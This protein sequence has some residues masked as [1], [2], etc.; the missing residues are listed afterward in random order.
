[1]RELHSLARRN[2]TGLLT[3]LTVVFIT[4]IFLFILS[5]AVLA[6]HEPKLELGISEYAQTD[7]DHAIV[8]KKKRKSTADHSEMKE[9][10]G[11]FFSGPDVTRACL[12]CHNTAG[13]QFMQNKH[14]TWDYKHPKPDSILG[15]AC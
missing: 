6:E 14:W 11:P 3:T 12:Q 1:M 10:E 15:K 5:G 7:E 8:S 4:S 2:R 13:H 9:L